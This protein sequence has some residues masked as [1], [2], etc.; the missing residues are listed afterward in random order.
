MAVVYKVNTFHRL[1]TVPDYG[2]DAYLKAM[3]KIKPDVRIWVLSEKTDKVLYRG[4]LGDYP[5]GHQ[6]DGGPFDEIDEKPIEAII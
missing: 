4:L 5:H 3:A 2:V 1:A 6:G